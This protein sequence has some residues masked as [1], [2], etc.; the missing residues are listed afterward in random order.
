M[1]RLIVIGQENRPNQI[2]DLDGRVISLGRS[3]ENHIQIDD[4]NSSRHHCEIHEQGEGYELIDKDSRNGIFLN[5]RRVTRHALEPTD[6]I[7]IGTTVI[8]WER[9]PSSADRVGRD[10]V[11]ISTGTYAAVADPTGVQGVMNSVLD[12]ARLAPDRTR[13][14]R[15]EETNPGV[16]RDRPTEATDIAMPEVGR[17]ELRELRQL[18]NLN[19]VFNTIRNLRRL[20]ETV[21]DTVIQVSGAERG[22][23]ILS[24]GGEI[25]VKVSR[26][27]D[28]ES[29][30]D[31]REKISE[32][33]VRDVLSDGKAVLLT[34]AAN[35]ERYGGRQSILNM[36][37]RSVLVVPLTHR[38]GTMG[39][40][41]LDNRF[42]SSRF[43]ATTQ[44]RLELVAASAAVA[45]ENARL[46]EENMRQQE[47]LLHA[48]EELERLNQLLRERVEVQDR[49][50]TKAREA[51]AAR[52]EAISLKYSYDNIVTASPK[53]LE[54][55]SILDKVTD[56]NVPVLIQG[57]SGTGKELVARAL[58]FNGPR[59]KLRFVSENCAAIPINLMES[60]FFGHVKG[61]FTGATTDKMGLFEVADGGTL[62]L[63]EIGDMDLDM[64][65]KLLRVLQ[66]GVLRRVGSKDF[67]RV[68][69]RI[70]SATNKDLLQC[71]KEGKFREDLYYR[72]N[73]IN[74]MLPPLRDRRE[75][76]PLLAEH[77]LK[78]QT[79][80]SGA[81]ERT[82]SDEVLDVFLR[83][84][85]QGNIRELEN[86][87]MRASALSKDLIGPEHLSRTVIEGA[88]QP[89]A[90]APKDAKVRGLLLTGKTLKELVAEEVDA[91]E[92][93]AITEVL[94][95]TGYKKSKAARV[96]G[97]SRPTL[98]AKIEKHGLTRA[99]VLE[100][101]P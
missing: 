51:L 10:T 56:S 99:Q 34:D 66:D 43:D 57:E 7:E 86:E 23:L 18:L 20:L 52:R 71:M 53:M 30:R 81:G 74:I 37:L 25:R 28:Q 31:A 72:L 82:L 41:Y 84:H 38:E 62:F 77:F 83:Y 32:T 1:P 35:D 88:R 33:L 76:V 13:R 46:F 36:K 89:L 5:G 27:I 68:N 91:L 87:I 3:S 16:T 60:E 98:D 11:D 96:L 69:V 59:R 44:D 22:F 17:G 9:L 6:K 12:T 26:N 92:T 50:L 93:T 78:Q 40:I 2:H 19:R 64:Q 4:L 95:R 58:H 55:F 15:E 79:R 42:A 75:D 24:E 54:I 80:Q 8:Y 49:Q 29:L 70:V 48:K 97:I 100:G 63:D 67:K 45:I 73:V 94:R 39:A 14:A 85:W 61:A 65:T 21:M 101:T 47:E 90:D